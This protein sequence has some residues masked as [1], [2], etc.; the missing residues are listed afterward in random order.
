[1]SSWPAAECYDVLDVHAKI[2]VGIKMPAA[3]PRLFTC[4]GSGQLKRRAVELFGPLY[5]DEN[6]EAL[7]VGIAVFL[8][9][10]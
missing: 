4:L 3:G 6:R 2:A 5:F 8:R 9:L 10:D 1:M 7:P